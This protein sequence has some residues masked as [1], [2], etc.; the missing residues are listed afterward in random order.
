W[1]IA[2]YPGTRLYWLGIAIDVAVLGWF[3][4]ANFTIGGLNSSLGLA[5]PA[6]SVVLPLGISFFTFQKIASL[7]GIRRREKDRGS[8]GEFTLLVWFFPQLIAGPI[9]RPNEFIPQWRA[10]RFDDRRVLVNLCVGLTLFCVG[11]I[12][13][14]AIADMVAPYVDVVFIQAAD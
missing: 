10:L 1:C 9:V 8:L 14:F 3:K 2:S 13:K 7:T 11:L 5:L 12:K 6:V 4:Y